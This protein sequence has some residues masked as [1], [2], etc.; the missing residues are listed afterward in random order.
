MSSQLSLTSMPE[1][2][3]RGIMMSFTVMRPRSRIDSSICRCRAGIT[4]AA[5]V[6][7]VRSSSALRVWVVTAARTTPNS[8][9]KP[10]AMVLVSHSAGRATSTSTR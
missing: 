3:C 10:Y 8:R 1:I 6:T 4:G 5:S 9:R 7:T 2:S